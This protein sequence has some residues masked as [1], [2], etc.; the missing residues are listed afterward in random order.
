[1]GFIH[2]ANELLKKTIGKS[3]LNRGRV[4]FQVLESSRIAKTKDRNQHLQRLVEGKVKTKYTLLNISIERCI[5]NILH[6]AT[7]IERASNTG[8]FEKLAN[9]L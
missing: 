9:I 6:M 7:Y 8:K 5:V 2:I 3:F 1:M 4:Q